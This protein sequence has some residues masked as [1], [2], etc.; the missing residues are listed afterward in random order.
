MS[1]FLVTF[2][3]AHNLDWVAEYLVKVPPIAHSHGGKF[4][5]VAKGIPN[6]VELVEGTAPAP[7]G[8]AII[9]FP[10]M[11]AVKSFLGA[12]EY[13][14]YKEARIAATESNFFAFE[15]DDNAPQFL[16]Q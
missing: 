15:N 14:P 3:T 7:Q 16:G 5:A 6:A 12:P 11:D 8:I 9:T 13:A 2:V 1:A 10:S 4:L